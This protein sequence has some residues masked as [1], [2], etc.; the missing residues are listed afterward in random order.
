MLVGA[1]VPRLLITTPFPPSFRVHKKHC[2]K[3]D[4][5]HIVPP[6][7]HHRIHTHHTTTTTP[8]RSA[9]CSHHHLSLRPVSHPRPRPRP[10]RTSTQ[11]L[12]SYSVL[13]SESFRL[14]LGGREDE[15][16]PRCTRCLPSPPIACLPTLAR[17][18]HAHG[19][20]ASL[21]VLHASQPDCKA[22]PVV[23]FSAALS[24]AAA[25][26]RQRSP[27]HQ[28]ARPQQLEQRGGRLVE[29]AGSVIES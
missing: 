22:R 18:D 21:H 19:G 17:T 13:P 6:P 15:A 7:S 2:S 27:L 16:S 3:K 1:P 23:W 11:V 5:A 20:L 10:Q 8:L 29:E 12:S 26:R 9:L 24:F 14:A 4:V 28:A 25:S